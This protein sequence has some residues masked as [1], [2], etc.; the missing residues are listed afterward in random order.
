MMEAASISETS[1]NCQQTTRRYNT[2]DSQPSLY[3]WRLLKHVLDLKKKARG[4]EV[5]SRLSKTLKYV[6]FANMRL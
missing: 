1:V 5:V 2:E 3:S 6:S 4:N